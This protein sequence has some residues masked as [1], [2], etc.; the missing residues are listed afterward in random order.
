[1]IFLSTVGKGK[2]LFILSRNIIIISEG[3]TDQI[4]AVTTMIP[5]TVS[6]RAD[7]G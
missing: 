4:S 7:A 2:E 1:M 5:V 6:Q 3:R